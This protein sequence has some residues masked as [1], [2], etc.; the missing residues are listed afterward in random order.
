MLFSE[1]DME[2]LGGPDP[3]IR[4]WTRLW[5]GLVVPIWLGMAMFALAVMV[6]P[7]GGWLTAT[8]WCVGLVPCLAVV[9]LVVTVVIAHVIA[10]QPSDRLDRPTLGWRW[11]C[12]ALELLLSLPFLV[13]LL[14]LLFPRSFPVG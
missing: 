10:Q 6:Q 5:A 14:L 12:V 9:H 3:R 7:E 4:R 8:L 1:A 2:S 13:V 11:A